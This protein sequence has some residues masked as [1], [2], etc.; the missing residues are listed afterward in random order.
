MAS[1][2]WMPGRSWMVGRRSRVEV[3]VDGGQ[4]VNGG[5]GPKE[6]AAKAPTEKLVMIIKS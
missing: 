3:E 2:K 1:K 5:G 6:G 4:E